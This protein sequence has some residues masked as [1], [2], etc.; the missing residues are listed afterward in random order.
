MASFITGQ[1]VAVG[2]H[3]ASPLLDMETVSH[4]LQS[5]PPCTMLHFGVELGM[6]NLQLGY[7]CRTSH[8]MLPPCLT[9]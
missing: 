5:P 8:D 4:L 7:S 9:H 1:P 3:D 2:R 6:E